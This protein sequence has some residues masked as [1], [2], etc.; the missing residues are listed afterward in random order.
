[1]RHAP[2]LLALPA[3]LLLAACGGQVVATTD[4]DAT[5]P[6]VGIFVDNAFGDGDFFDQA[7][8]AVDPLEAEYDATVT[9]YEAQLDAANFVSLL[10]DAGAANDI[11]FVLGF[12]AIDAL[13][14][15]ASTDDDT[16]FVF[17]DA[18]LGD[19][20]IV[21]AVF[22][23]QEGCFLAGAL[24]GSIDDGDRVPGSVGFIGGVD[25]P[26]VVNCL[27]GFT[28]GVEAVAPDKSV[29]SRY[30][31][32]F[33]DPATAKE[34]AIAMSEAGAFATFQ[35]A[36]LSGSGAFDAATSGTNIRPIGVVAD[37]SGL[38]PGLVPGSL[39]MGV[40]SAILGIV[41]QFV[42]GALEPGAT[43]EFGVA[44]GGWTLITDPEFVDAETQARLDEL[45]QGIIDGTITVT[46]N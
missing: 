38:A 24:A 8:A 21:S 3:V 4:D 45:T 29:D 42:E 35:Y 25:A 27:E 36:G 40:D 34:I 5:G 44:D 9:T 37:K 2:H 1:M 39:L 12:E 22:K 14:E 31:G 26:V 16:T 23:T 7:A 43:V 19:S 30:V 32:S 33:V 46:A 18:D 6:R 28:L 41:G 11:V 10:E 20:T 15:V 17:V 13:F